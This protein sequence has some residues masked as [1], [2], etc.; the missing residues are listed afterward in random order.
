MRIATS[1]CPSDSSGVDTCGFGFSTLERTVIRTL[2]TQSRCAAVSAG[3]VPV[4]TSST[5]GFE[6]S[7]YRRTK[8]LTS[9]FSTSA[10]DSAVPS[11][12][13]E[14]AAEGE[15]VESLGLVDDVAVRVQVLHELDLVELADE[16]PLLHARAASPGRRGRDRRAR[17]V[18][19]RHA[20]LAAEEVDDRTRDVL[21][22]RIRP[23]RGE[24]L[25]LRRVE[26]VHAADDDQRERGA[27]EDLG[28]AEPVLRPTRYPLGPHLQ[29]TVLQRT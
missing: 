4:G 28:E 29:G 20:E 17:R 27:D 8:P 11:C 7:K 3:G 13:A 1:A 16:Q 23:L 19:R 25:G 24:R 10:T 2:A 22:A 21:A 18:V 26:A 14:L 15:V 5:G 12:A 9:R 6:L